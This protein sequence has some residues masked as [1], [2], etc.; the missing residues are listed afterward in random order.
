M[1]HLS[2][3]LPFDHSVIIV[4]AL[5]F[6]W[7]ENH[8]FMKKMHSG[9]TYRAVQWSWFARVNA[10]CNL[11]RKKS[12]EVAASFPGRY[13]S[14][15]YFTLCVTMEVEPRIAKQYKCQHCCSCKNYGEREWRV[16][17]KSVF[18]L[19]FCWSEDC[20]FVEKNVYIYSY[21]IL[22]DIA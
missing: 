11:L 5:F 2:Q 9:A 22:R 18:V 8:E 21:F 20:E 12:W 14:R 13:L 19:F 1:S 10:L 15:R 4:F 16:G 6:G 17:K 7:P 3:V